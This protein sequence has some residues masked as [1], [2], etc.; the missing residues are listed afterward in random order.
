MLCD[1]D[2][3]KGVNDSLGH[4]AGDSA[5]QAFAKIV[6]KSLRKHDAAFRIGGD[7]FALLL[8]EASE[9]DTREVI[10]RIQAKLDRASDRLGGMRASFGVAE[11]PADATDA[12]SL[13]RRADEALYEAKRAGTGI[14]FV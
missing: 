9:A 5:L 3:F 1:L 2:G 10:G 7:E 13:F 4:P 11:C 8:A 12:Q 14:H 6:R